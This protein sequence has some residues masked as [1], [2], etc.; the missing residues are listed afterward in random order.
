MNNKYLVYL[1]KISFITIYYL[2]IS[3]PLIVSAAQ[4]TLEW[5]GSQPAPEGYRVFKSLVKGEYSGAPAW[6][7]AQTACTLNDLQDNTTYFFVVRAYQGDVESGNSN[8]VEYYTVTTPPV[9]PD[10]DDDGYNDDVDAFPDDPNEWLDTDGDGIGNNADEDDDGDGMPDSWEKQYG[11]DPL[12]DDAG[13]DLDGDGVSN[14]DEYKGGTDP[15]QVPGNIAPRKTCAAVARKWYSL[16]ARSR[17][18]CR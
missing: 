12:T 17:S 3:F 1:S 15:S 18:D 16:R 4:V 13:G 2:L 5:N 9:D 6:F 14:I 7:G 11:L 8:E 10:R